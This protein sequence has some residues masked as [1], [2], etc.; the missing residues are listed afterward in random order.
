MMKTK[1]QK[2]VI[3][4]EKRNDILVKSKTVIGNTKSTAYLVSLQRTMLDN[5]IKMLDEDDLDI[6]E[7]KGRSKKT[8]ILSEIKK[9]NVWLRAFDAD[10]F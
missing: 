1:K 5:Y 6:C 3:L 8:R 10:F 4:K 2:K 9:V 7:R